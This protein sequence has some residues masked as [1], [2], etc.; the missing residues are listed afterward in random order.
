MK[1]M[2][3][4]IH[5]Y[6]HKKKTWKRK[7]PANEETAKT[8]NDTK[9]KHLWMMSIYYI[10]TGSPSPDPQPAYKNNNIEIII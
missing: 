3:K 1:E 6:M 10:E 2:N 5:I 4:N 7:M 8:E 9:W